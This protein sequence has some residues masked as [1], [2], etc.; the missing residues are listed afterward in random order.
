MAPFASQLRRQLKA[1][2]EAIER[3]EARGEDARVQRVGAHLM[4]PVEREMR[5]LAGVRLPAETER[6]AGRLVQRHGIAPPRL[7]VIA[8]ENRRPRRPATRGVVKLR[9]AQPLARKRVKIGRG[10]FP[11]IAPQI[12]IA[13]VI[14]KDD[15]DV[16]FRC[17]ADAVR[18]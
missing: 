2:V 9:E 5:A 12:G 13:H 8:G 15:D 4:V 6:D 14:G 7:C 17:S 18:P 16:W 3:K 1:G 11:T 10:D